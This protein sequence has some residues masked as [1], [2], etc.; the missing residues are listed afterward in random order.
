M[1]IF[2]NRKE[3]K[4]T[5]MKFNSQSGNYEAELENGSKLIVDADAYAEQLKQGVP[6]KELKSSVLWENCVDGESVRIEPK[7]K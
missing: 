1:L 4:V 7:K 2:I 6:E 3:R 5:E